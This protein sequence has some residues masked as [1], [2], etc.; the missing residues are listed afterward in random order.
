MFG[1][2][3]T[4]LAWITQSLIVESCE[5]LKLVEMDDLY[6]EPTLI[7]F[8]LTWLVVMMLIIIEW[9]IH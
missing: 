8:F 1:I 4:K 7:N 6:L 5:P 3:V 9:F 2:T